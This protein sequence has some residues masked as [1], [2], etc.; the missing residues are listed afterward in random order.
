MKKHL[1]FLL[2][3]LMVIIGIHHELT[4]YTMDVM[5]GSQY[6]TA[7]VCVCLTLLYILP[8]LALVNY[9]SRRW[10]LEIRLPLYGLL[11][12]A[13]IAGWLSSYGNGLVDALL[14]TVLH[15]KEAVDAWGAPTAPFIE[16]PAKAFAAFAALYYLYK[17]KF[18][19]KQ[20]L[21]AGITAGL[22]FQIAE[23]ISYINGNVFEGFSYSIA[24]IFIRM[25]GAIGSH[26]TYTAMTTFGLYLAFR[27]DSKKTDKRFGFQLVGGAILIHL[28]WN[29]PITSLHLGFPMIESL[30][31]LASFFGV[32]L[33]YEKAMELDK[34]LTD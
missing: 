11:S 31:C 12:G 3:W 17:K 24:D 6:G 25:A 2:F 30:I 18:G 1:P 21:M 26:W 16:E 28:L 10:E 32:K 29:T 23:D 34:Q 5:T 7:F 13:F 27:K 4:P 22:G 33:A 9:F 8:A 14:G 15:S 19:P 20:V